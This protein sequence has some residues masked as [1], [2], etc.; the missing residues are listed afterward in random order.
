VA[1]EGGSGRGGE[2]ARPVG[3]KDGILRLLATGMAVEA[4]SNDVEAVL[5]ETAALIGEK[6]LLPPAQAA[7]LGK[8]GVEASVSELDAV[9]SLSERILRAYLA[10]PSDSSLQPDPKGQ[11]DH[12]AAL[13]YAE[14]LVRQEEV[15]EALSRLDS[16]TAP[17][18]AGLTGADRKRVDEYLLYRNVRGRFETLD[19]LVDLWE[20]SVVWADDSGE[21]YTHDEY[22]DRLT[23]RDSLEE[24]RSL[25]SPAARETLDRRVRPLD[26]RF[27]DATRAVSDSISPCSPWRPQ[28]WW[29]FRVP[30]VL[31]RHFQ[32]R[33]EHVAP[34][35][36]TEARGRS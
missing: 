11:K 34:A 30:R 4:I 29:W 9:R 3:E 18:Y 15:L 35:A 20:R 22:V 23:S 24:A 27:F 33:L 5:R 8:P 2:T 21:S 32:E 1:S 6:A 28:R 17:L 26:E 19:S 12:Y 31:G 16:G 13:R 25:V 7:L 10:G 14:A 36:A